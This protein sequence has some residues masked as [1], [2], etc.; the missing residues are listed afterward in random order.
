[1]RLQHQMKLCTSWWFQMCFIFIPIWARFQNLTIIFQMGW[2][3]HQLVLFE[4]F[5]SLRISD[6]DP[7]ERVGQL[8]FSAGFSFKCQ[9]RDRGMIRRV[10]WNLGPKQ[11]GC[12][13]WSCSKMV[14]WKIVS[15]VFQLSRLSG[16]LLSGRREALHFEWNI[17]QKW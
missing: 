9:F 7:E 14:I 2:F 13:C 6:L 10:W 1:M 5:L 16:F 17:A 4:M 15:H 8:C 12:F 11:K 3:N